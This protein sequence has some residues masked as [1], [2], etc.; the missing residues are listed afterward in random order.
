MSVRPGKKFG[1]QSAAENLQWRRWPDCLQQTVQYH[2]NI[3]IKNA[4]LMC[5][6]PNRI[7]LIAR[8]WS[9][10]CSLHLWWCANN[11]CGVLRNDHKMEIIQNSASVQFFGTHLCICLP[12]LVKIEYGTNA[13][14]TRHKKLAHR[15]ND[16]FLPCRKFFID[17]RVF[18]GPGKSWNWTWVRKK[19]WKS[20][21]F[22]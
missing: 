21:E 5:L 14:Y 16:V 1:F 17:Y 7:N 3:F 13:G 19:S 2:R 8:I 6:I 20:P 15:T 4:S 9:L 11:I 10:F 22:C 18:T 12:S